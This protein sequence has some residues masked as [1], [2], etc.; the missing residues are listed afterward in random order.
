MT[1]FLKTV[2]FFVGSPGIVIRLLNV[3]EIVSSD[4]SL[5]NRPDCNIHTR[6]KHVSKRLER[7]VFM[8]EQRALPPSNEAPLSARARI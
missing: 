4:E 2:R 5:Q 1:Q 6:S 3:L 8:V 7:A